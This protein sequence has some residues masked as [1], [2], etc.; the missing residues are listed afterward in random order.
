ME[1]AYQ[2][3]IQLSEGCNF[4]HACS[5]EPLPQPRPDPDQAAF[6][7]C[8]ARVRP[9]ITEEGHPTIFDRRGV[10][11]GPDT[12]RLIIQVSYMSRE[13]SECEM[14]P[15]PVESQC[16]IAQA[17]TTALTT[18]PKLLTVNTFDFRNGRL[19]FDPLK[20]KLISIDFPI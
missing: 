7:I 20:D 11:W 16:R 3:A 18:V 19:N 12:S 8:R 4:A 1:L 2:R 6:I 14:L 9:I 15:N 10:S 17:A 13:D 5:K